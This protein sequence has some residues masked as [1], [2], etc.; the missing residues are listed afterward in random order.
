MRPIAIACVPPLPEAAT[1]P[2]E[3]ADAWAA[4]LLDIYEKRYGRGKVEEDAESDTA[5]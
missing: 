4:V 2:D 1:L 5:G 3:V